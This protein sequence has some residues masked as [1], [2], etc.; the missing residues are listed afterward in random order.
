M[1]VRSQITCPILVGRDADLR[2]LTRLLEQTRSGRFSLALVSGEA[3]S[4]KSRLVAE[5]ATFARTAEF[6]MLTGACS[7]PDGEFP[8]APFIDALRQRLAQPDCEAATL[9]GPQGNV[10]LE[11]LPELGQLGIVRDAGAELSPEQ[12]KRRLF[13]A[14][15]AVLSREATRAPLLLV[16]EDLHWADPTSLELLDLL[17]RR[18]RDWPVSIIGTVREHEVNPHLNK[19]I[20]ALRRAR[21]L[22]EIVLDPLGD[23]DV[24]SMIEA[25]LSGGGSHALARLVQ[26]R[27][28][29]NPFFVEELLATWSYDRDRMLTHL[30]V[31]LPETVSDTVLR[32]LSGLSAD[33]T[34]VVQVMSVAG[35]AADLE[36]LSSASGLGMAAT[37]AAVGVLQKRG[38]VELEGAPG[39][40]RAVF[41]HALTRD[42]VHG[43][44]EP[45]TRAAL[46]RSI[47]QSIELAAQARGTLAS[48]S[49]E[50]GYHYHAA[51]EWEKA[52]EYAQ[53]AGEAAWSVLAAVEALGHFRRALDAALALGHSASAA[54]HVRC[55]QALD[56]LGAFDPARAHFEEALR[57][58]G[59]EG[60]ASIEQ[61]T[62]YEMAGLFASRDYRQAHAYAEQA[63][64]LAHAGQDR[65]QEGMALN[66]LGNILTNTQ[67]FDEGRRLHEQALSLFTALDDDWGSADCLDL[68][69]MSRYL[70]GDV[71]GARAALSRAMESF[72]E[73]HAVER[74][75]S[76]LIT[77][78]NTIAVIDGPCATDATPTECQ[79]DVER[80]LALCRALGWRS[81]EAY[82][83]VASACL[84]IFEG[85]AGQALAKLDSALSI[86]S[87]IEHQQWTVIARVALG[88]LDATILDDARAEAQFERGL[89]VAQRIGAVQWETRLRAWIARCRFRLGDIVT[90]E[91]MLASLLPDG[92]LP[93]SIGQR[94]AVFTYAEMLLARG[95]PL[96]ARRETDRL[97]AGS[98]RHRSAE[99]LMLQAR[100]LAATGAKVEADASL[101]DA[102]RIAG[103]AGPRSVLWQAAALSAEL[104]RERDSERYLREATLART[105]IAS[106]A[107]AI[108]NDDWRAVFLSAPEIRPWVATARGARHRGKSGQDGLTRR[109]GEVLGL[110][111]TGLTNKE[112]ASR[113]SLAEKTVEMHVGN[114]LGKLAC[115]TRTQLT[116]H[117]ITHGLVTGITEQG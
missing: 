32:R 110:V 14:F 24:A 102:R 104:W 33:I 117:A 13:E 68:I 99:A 47:A 101:D 4:S 78:G 28:G 69:G 93:A 87:E 80:G 70:S 50:L 34:A 108:P 72:D 10:L 100:A 83:L 81:G 35:Q 113:L 48:L 98:R 109:E 85:D 65:R 111:A 46:H 97:L 15:V 105:E 8:F 23:D 19:C 44:I 84:A 22:T 59:D 42:A 31:E 94:R 17:P 112:I 71:P 96:E 1:P 49:G 88:I 3:G 16:L 36:M 26:S 58:S 82:A 76:A 64:A 63:L 60:N 86:A 77:R 12:S 66:R 75:A 116:A 61:A 45:A 115:A 53:P 91:T 62:L 55:G 89:A 79:A 73:Q 95:Q 2:S 37:T 107:E 41:K 27:A 54:L 52:R 43:E 114:C 67:R 56:L 92:E 51:G 40:H 11:L 57:L 18:L 74:V 103:D 38:I 7:E 20:A 30:D 29:G 106:I 90:A 39:R 25:L 6:A 5:A 21:V 9:L